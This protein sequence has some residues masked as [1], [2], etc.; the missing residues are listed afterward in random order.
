M[1]PY[2]YKEV[3]SLSLMSCTSFSSL[4]TFCLFLL[5]L[6]KDAKS[7]LKKNVASSTI[8]MNPTWPLKNK[9]ETCST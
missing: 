2:N 7:T 8:Q 5:S 6:V 1:S 9:K 4:Q 3:Q